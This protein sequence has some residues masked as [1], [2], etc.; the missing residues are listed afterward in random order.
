GEDLEATIDALSRLVEITPRDRRRF[1]R[2]REESRTFESIPIRT[3]LSDEEVARFA[4]QR[5]RFPGVDIQARLFRHYPYGELAS[6]VLG[7]IGRINRSEEHTSELQSR[8][9]LVCR[10]LLEKKNKET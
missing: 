4:A 9:N 8:E 6:H 10:L 5:F 3:R 1:K 7:Y 2:V